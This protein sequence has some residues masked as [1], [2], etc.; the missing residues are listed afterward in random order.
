MSNGQQISTLLETAVEQICS[1][2][3]AS[4]AVIA[5]RDPDGACCLASAGNAPAVG[6]RLQP[7]SAF[8]RECFET[9]EVVICYD[10]ENDSRILPSVVKSLHLRS[11]VAVPIQMQ[12]CAIGVIEVFSSRP[13]DI[14]RAAVD[15]L[16]ECADLVA[17]LITPWAAPSAQHVL[18]VA[19][20]TGSS[21]ADFLESDKEDQPSV[22][23][24]WFSRELTP[25]EQGA[26]SPGQP[27]AQF[28][29]RSDFRLNVFTGS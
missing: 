25:R 10:A 7:D 22:C 8:T 21:A 11:A 18:K 12:G 23:S 13:S 16:E 20:A 29:R 17:P 19:S 28:S 2:M 6:S 9:G 3:S 24:N 5:V 4:G 14:Q 15:M 27:V 26:D 1:A